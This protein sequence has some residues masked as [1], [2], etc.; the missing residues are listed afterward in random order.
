M[1]ELTLLKY[2]LLAFKN[3]IYDSIVKS[4]IRF[5]FS[6]SFFIVIFFLIYHFFKVTYAFFS[7]FENLKFDLWFSNTILN[8]IFFFN[9]IFIAVSATILSYNIIY[10]DK[11]MLLL[12]FTK[13]PRRAIFFEVF[14]RTTITSSW[15]FLVLSMPLLLVQFQQYKI[16]LFSSNMIISALLIA[17]FLLLPNVI[18]VCI[19]LFMP[20]F[21][22]A[23][24]LVKVVLFAAVVAAFAFLPYLDFF[25]TN[26]SS[27]YS[28]I[29]I[30]QTLKKF[31]FLEHPLLPTYWLTS[32]LNGFF[33]YKF[34][35]DSTF[36][37]ITT[38]LVALVWLYII[39]KAS[40]R[41]MLILST[42]YIPDKNI[43]IEGII[44]IFRKFTGIF[45]WKKQFL[46][47]KDIAIFL[48]DGRFWGQLLLFIGI[49]ALYFMNLSESDLKEGSR[50]VWG[51]R[52]KWNELI[53][54]LNIIACAFMS[55]AL[56]GRALF[57]QFSIEYAKL[58]INQ[59][60]GY[61][62]KEIIH[63]KLN[64]IGI[65]IILICT[66]VVTASSIVLK[67]SIAE[68]GYALFHCIIFSYTISNMALKLGVLFHNKRSDNPVIVFSGPGGVIYIMFGIFYITFNAVLMLKI[69][70]FYNE[71]TLW[72]TI[73]ILENILINGVL[74]KISNRVYKA[75]EYI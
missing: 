39:F 75:I 27:L 62:L 41:N 1:Y 5:F 59:F 3:Y 30:V 49:F 20:V 38:T 33:N 28:E 72:V 9:F 46:S 34:K 47:L 23:A 58:W 16:P 10:K 35:E 36:I 55:S 69:G 4:K 42:R 13:V 40:F 19:G 60:S 68:L 32:T 66:S 52:I 17:L 45:A 12:Y 74:N 18:G 61:S 26:W 21:F 73:L 14:I 11:N 57:P 15:S 25:T 54:N 37:L 7:G 51:E 43:I 67:V 70:L 29:W 24:S 22:T 6:L 31:A 48:R 65:F 2:R 64:T 53:L 8:G 56:A 63:Y 50:W 71:K 44:Y